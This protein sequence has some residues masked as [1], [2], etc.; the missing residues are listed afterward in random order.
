MKIYLDTY[1]NEVPPKSWTNSNSMKKENKYRKWTIEEKESIIKSILSGSTGVR[2]VA[3]EKN[4]SSTLIYVWIEKYN[5][6]GVSGLNRQISL[7]DNSFKKHVILD[8]FENGLSLRS[9]AKKYNITPSTLRSWFHKYEKMG[10]TA[11]A[12]DSDH[13]IVMKIS[14]E[15]DKES[16]DQTSFC[17]LTKQEREELEYL[18]AENAYLKKLQAL[19]QEKQLKQSKGK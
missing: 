8:H 1:Q 17:D 14:N 2:T 6:R 10:I 15:R 5:N 11:F 13:N 16:K 19:V 3:R 12:D 7:F 9:T 18:R 4:I